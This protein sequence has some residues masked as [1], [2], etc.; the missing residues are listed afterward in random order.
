DRLPVPVDDHLPGR[1][2][3]R[4]RPSRQPAVAVLTRP[5]VQRVVVH[6]SPCALPASPAA[7]RRAAFLLKTPQGRKT[8]R[9]PATS[10]VAAPRASGTSNEHRTA[11]PNPSRGRTLARV[12]QPHVGPARAPRP[13]PVRGG[14]RGGRGPR[15]ARGE[16]HGLLRGRRLR[17][18]RALRP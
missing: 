4:E 10:W 9:A 14:G 15:R 1:R 13:P 3:A 18:R 11:A 7:L 5:G 2:V 16:R 6:A 17:L 12:P 8:P